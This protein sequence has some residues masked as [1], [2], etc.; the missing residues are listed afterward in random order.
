M[1]D[2]TAASPTPAPEPIV[3]DPRIVRLRDLRDS[4][5]AAATGAGVLSLVLAT[6]AGFALPYLSIMLWCGVASLLTGAATVITCVCAATYHVNYKEALSHWEY[7]I[8]MNGAPRLTH[9]SGGGGAGGRS[10]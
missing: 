8:S 3:M 4:C 1:T 7:H 10:Y 6:A 2:T 9:G 5:V